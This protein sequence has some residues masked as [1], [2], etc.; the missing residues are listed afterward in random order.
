[1][2]SLSSDPFRLVDYLVC[3]RREACDETR[4][5]LCGSGVDSYDVSNIFYQLFGFYI[6][7]EISLVCGW[8]MF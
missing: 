2:I 6:R 5:F 7:L 4:V 8:D 3:F 1:M